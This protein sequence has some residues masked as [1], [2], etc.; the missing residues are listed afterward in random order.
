[1]NNNEKDELMVTIR[2]IT[3]NHEPYIRQCLD[4]FV[5]QKTNFRFEAIVHDDAS[6]DGTADIIREYAEKYPDI[7][8]PILQTENQYSKHD[9]SIRR[10]LN[11]HTHGKYVAMCEGDDYWI[12]P[13]KL[14]K[15]VDFLEENPNHSLCF[16]A[17]S[18]L[19]NDGNLSE[20]HQF[21]Q[22]VIDVPKE[23]MILGGGGYMATNSMLYV[24]KYYD[25]IP[26]WI[27]K[28]PVGDA[29]L[30]LLLLEM[31]KVAY[32]ND[33]MSVYRILSLGSWS[34]RISNSYKKMFR[35]HRAI[36]KMWNEFDRWSGYKYH[37]IVKK[38]KFRNRKSFFY[39]TIK[40]L[41]K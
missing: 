20:V 11:E 7:I 8:K 26:E 16:H 38:K 27:K 18:K 12:D 36:I 9:G 39:T 34:S 17:Y 22:D 15:Q 32:I 41:L 1:M 14:Q 19:F 28:A 25:N 10:I 2:C 29:P 35:H 40:Y 30:M 4:G 21:S 23:N 33:N 5:M 31:G 37:P 13:L 3:Y 24:R 6:T